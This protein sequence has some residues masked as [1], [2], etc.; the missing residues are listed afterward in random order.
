MIGNRR[1]F[2]KKEKR[3]VAFVDYEH[4]FISMDTLYNRQKPDLAAWVAD[5]GE[6]GRVV[7]AI[8]F[9]DFSNRIR[10]SAVTNHASVCSSNVNGNYISLFMNN[11]F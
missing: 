6:R 9:G 2:S 11:F 4:W 8:F 5:L 1:L 10:P 3:I 7:D